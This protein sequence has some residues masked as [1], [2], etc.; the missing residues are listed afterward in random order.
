MKFMVVASVVNPKFDVG[1][2][3]LVGNELPYATNNTIIEIIEVN[4]AII[5]I[6]E[7]C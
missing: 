1:N 5:E 4:E 3:F 7:K 6:V 2:V